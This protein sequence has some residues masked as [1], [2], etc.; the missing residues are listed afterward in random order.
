MGFPVRNKRPKLNFDIYLIP[1]VITQ[2]VYKKSKLVA[3]TLAGGPPVA[4]AEHLV[5]LTPLTPRLTSRLERKTNRFKA[6]TLDSV[7]KRIGSEMDRI[8]SLAMDFEDFEVFM[9]NESTR[10]PSNRFL[11]DRNLHFQSKF[12]PIPLPYQH[13][14]LYQV[15]T[16]YHS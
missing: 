12:P 1:R 13:L 5:L 15:H 3:G 16:T 11:R 6:Q 9:P 4:T 7:Q 2:E 14:I 10:C 8:G